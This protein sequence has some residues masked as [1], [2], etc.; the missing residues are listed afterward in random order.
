MPIQNSVKLLEKYGVLSSFVL[1]RKFKI[2]C[3]EARI[4]LSFLINNYD[5]VLWN[6]QDQVYIDGLLPETSQKKKRKSKF[7]DVTKP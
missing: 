7:I 1:M 3:D 5:N 6:G 2:S 4:I